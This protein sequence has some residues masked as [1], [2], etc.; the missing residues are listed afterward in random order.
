MIN[1]NG[2]SY[3]HFTVKK[4]LNI[5]D[6]CKIVAGKRGLNS[7]IRSV[8]IMDS[9]DISWLKR[10]DLL[11]TTGYIFKDDSETQIKLIQDLAERDC[12]GLAIKV[13]RF[14][15]TIP[16]PMIQEAN[17]LGF[18][19]LEIPYERLLSDML[20]AVTR[21]ILKSES[22]FNEQVRR[23]DFISRLLRGELANETAVLSQG[24][25]YGILTG[26]EYVVLY[27]YENAS[28]KRKSLSIDKSILFKAMNEV[29]N[30]LH[31]KL[32]G[33]QLDDFVIIVQ[34]YRINDMFHP[35]S[36]K[37]RKAAC[38]LVKSFAKHNEKKTISIGIG[39]RQSDV[40]DIHTSFQEAKE[41][42]YLGCRVT[43]G[44][45]GAIHEYT[46]LEPE[47]LLQHLP[48]RELNRYFTATVE[49]LIIYDEENGTELFQTL[50]IYLYCGGKLGDAARILFVHRNT[51]KFRIA[52]IEELLGISLADGNVSFR[53]QLG[54]C[55]SRLLG[56][57][58]RFA[59]PILDMLKEG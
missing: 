47:A 1:E 18:P 59:E 32:I 10:G 13:K 45:N 21:E 5:L 30:A 51:V 40:R 16:E 11:L 57:S 53:L 48:D 23:R 9:P 8:S 26:C 55:A 3:M 28:K 12:A 35:V 37:A 34:D 52:R 56:V 19:I 25:E 38:M 46:A 2:G 15:S 49:K 41:A 27:I 6:C 33:E 4:A 14:L 43:S 42:V 58:S 7:S 31:V 54:M 20:F 17:R 39:T 22:I 50:E 44:G 29:G 36:E 24:H